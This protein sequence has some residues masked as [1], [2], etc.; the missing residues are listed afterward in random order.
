MGF[1]TLRDMGGSETVIRPGD[2]RAV[3]KL[4]EGAFATVEAA[5]YSPG[6]GP[7]PSTASASA[8]TSLSGAAPASAPAPPLT[9]PPAAAGSGRRRSVEGPGFLGMGAGAAECGGGVPPARL[10]AVKRLKPE[11]VNHQH[12]LESFLSEVALLKK[13]SHKR[14]V[15]FIGVGSA[16]VSSGEARRRTLFLVQEFMDGGTLK[17]MVS[18]QMLSVGRPVYS[19]ADAFRWALHIA[20]GLEY[21][22]SA[23]PVV[24]HRDLKLENILLKGTDPATSEAKIADF[25]LVALVRPRPR[26]P[27]QAL[28]ATERPPP[29]AASLRSRQWAAIGRD[30]PPTVQE[31]WAQ[32]FAQAQ[33]PGAAS[34]LAAPQHLSGRT[35]SYMY[36]APEMYLEEDY[37]EKV[38][39]FSFGVILFE[40]LSRY[41]MLCAI[42][43]AGTE[44]EVE[45]YAARVAQGYRPPLPASW[46]EAVLELVGQCWAQEPDARPGMGEVRSRLAALAAEGLPQ[47]MDAAREAASGGCQCVVC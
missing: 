26:N 9:P 3:R 7:G 19:S 42:S 32:S 15:D 8:T 18:R 11:V 38:D 27:A 4:G 1:A 23:R 43:V 25:G 24:I 30:A 47:A 5:V 20:E 46:P 39:V 29:P 36:M 10:V 37:N 44:E 6:P 31:A 28:A 22:H 33:R 13:L 17:K 45:G 40:V 14:V 12:D 16:D 34:G 21:L 2:L 41:Q 35:G